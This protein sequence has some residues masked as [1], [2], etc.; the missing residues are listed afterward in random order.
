VAPVSSEDT[1]ERRKEDSDQIW[2]LSRRV[3]VGQSK[4]LHPK[5]STK[6]VTQRKIDVLNHANATDPRSY[7]EKAD[8]VKE[9]S[10]I[11]CL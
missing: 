4:S 6:K 11:E 5:L 1:K 2:A 3:Y 9:I 8:Y 7:Q 10:S